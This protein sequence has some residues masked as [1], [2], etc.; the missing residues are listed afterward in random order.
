MYDDK[1]SGKL[2]PEVYKN[3]RSNRGSIVLCVNSNLQIGFM[4]RGVIKISNSVFTF[5]LLDDLNK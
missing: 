3:T 5:V 4:I 2:I 1:T